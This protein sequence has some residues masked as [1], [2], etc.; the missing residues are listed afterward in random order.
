MIVRR[1]PIMQL[2]VVVPGSVMSSAVIAAPRYS[3]HHVAIAVI[4]LLEYL[5]SVMVAFGSSAIS[6][7]VQASPQ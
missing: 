2:H 6:R 1:L 7:G 4:V 5:Q 3:L